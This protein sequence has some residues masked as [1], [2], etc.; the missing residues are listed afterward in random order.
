MAVQRV[1]VS[2]ITVAPAVAGSF[3]RMRVG[4]P[5]VEARQRQVHHDHVRMQLAR[6]RER[7]VAVGGLATRMPEYARK[8]VQRAVSSIVHHQDERRIGR[9]GALL[10]RAGAFAS[11]GFAATLAPALPSAL[12]VFIVSSRATAARA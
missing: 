9:R 7:L 4:L 6:F 1:S 5:A 10:R 8:R 11:A 3:F 2:A 12:R